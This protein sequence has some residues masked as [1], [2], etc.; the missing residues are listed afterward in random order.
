MRMLLVSMRFKNTFSFVMMKC[1]KHLMA[2]FELY[3]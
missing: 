2:V 1:V 3:N